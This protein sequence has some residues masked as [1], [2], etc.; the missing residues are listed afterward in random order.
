MNGDP[1]TFRA[2]YALRQADE[3]LGVLFGLVIPRG[4]DPVCAKYI[5]TLAMTISE[6]VD[7][8]VKH[9]DALE[10]KLAVKGKNDDAR[11]P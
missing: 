10:A 7:E 8:A 4:E 1:S 5:H 3:F 2:R 9:L 6:H 11:D